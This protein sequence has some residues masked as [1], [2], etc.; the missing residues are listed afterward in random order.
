MVKPSCRTDSPTY[1]KG[2][3]QALADFAIAKHC[4]IS[5]AVA[6]LGASAQIANLELLEE[7]A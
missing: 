2:Y 1:Q 6:T 5:A 4:C 3:Q 7:A